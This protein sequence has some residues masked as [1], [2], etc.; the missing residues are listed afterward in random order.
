M[1]DGNVDRDSTPPFKAEAPR[2]RSWRFPV[3]R[4][5]G[6]TGCLLLKSLMSCNYNIEARNKFP[7]PPCPDELD[8]PSMQELKVAEAAYSVACD[9]VA[10]ERERWIE[11][12]Q[13]KDKEREEE[14]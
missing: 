3:K 7:L 5:V 1:A 2:G 12:E 11:R 14:L 10:A 9:H 6:R 13:V 4:G 8:Y